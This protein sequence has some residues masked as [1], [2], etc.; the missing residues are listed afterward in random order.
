MGGDE[1]YESPFKKM[2]NDSKFHNAIDKV[3]EHWRVE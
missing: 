2:W 3:W 1:T